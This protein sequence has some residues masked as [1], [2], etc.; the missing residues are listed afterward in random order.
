MLILSLDL[1][2]RTGFAI[3][4]AGTIPR[5]GAKLLAR[6]DEN[7]E[8]GAAELGRFLRDMFVLE[9]PDLVVVE[10]EMNPSVQLS[11]AVVFWHL[12]L[13]GA[14]ASICGC[15][16]GIQI[17]KPTAATA[18]AH[19]CGQASAAPKRARG[20]TRTA[21]E[22]KADRDATNKMV[23]ARAVLLGYLPPAPVDWDK[24]SACALF[25]YAA[26]RFARVGP[27]SL[28]MFG[29]GT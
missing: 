1:G 20:H 29:G 18:R 3:G 21:A 7:H 22:R 28:T 13:H 24:A 25:D 5:V 27:S 2:R 11:A 17:E 26:A 10:Q 9:K 12:Y 16:S 4:K 8:A 6:A 23:F 19:F 15:Y 14:V